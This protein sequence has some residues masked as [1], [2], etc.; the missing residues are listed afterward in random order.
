[1]VQPGN[2]RGMVYVEGDAIHKSK[3][4]KPFDTI[5]IGESV[6]K[7]VP[8]CNKKFNWSR[9]DGENE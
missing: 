9:L 3:E 8:F 5:E 1:M 7:Y 4:L 2:S 6:F